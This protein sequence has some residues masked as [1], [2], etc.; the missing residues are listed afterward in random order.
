M[1]DATEIPDQLDP[2]R[3]RDE[4]SMRAVWVRRLI[5]AVFALFILAG[6]AGVFG[7]TAHVSQAAGPAA[8]L[9]VSAPTAVRG[10]LLFMGLF[11][12]QATAEV[13]QPTLVL[14]PGWTDDITINTVEPAPLEETSRNRRLVLTFPKL[15][16]GD[17]LRVWMEFQVNP[18]AI[19][20]SNQDVILRDGSTPIARV[21]RSVTIYP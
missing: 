14:G 21:D 10:G 2:T 5:L 12:I 8:T 4:P 3:H 20:R 1:A 15:A 6:L 7:Q 18:T 17:H 9:R 19:G 11:D 16:R 13:K